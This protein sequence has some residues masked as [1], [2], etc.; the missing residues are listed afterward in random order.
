MIVTAS[1]PGKLLLLGDHAVVYDHPCIVTAVD[2]RYMVTLETVT[3]MNITISTPLLEKKKISRIVSLED[4]G[5]SSIQETSFVEAA[6]SNVFRKFN[7]KSG[8]LMH[9]NGPIESYGLGSSSAVV[10]ATISALSLA[11]NLNLSP[12]QI[13]NLAYQAVLDVQGKGSGFDVA[14]AIWGGTL[15]YVT[16]GKTIEPLNIDEIPITI[17]YSGKKVSTANLVEQVYKLRQK[18]PDIIDTI[19]ALS[20][21]LVDEA[22]AS[23][24]QSDWLILGELLN[25]NQG[26]LDALG[27]ST[28]KLANLIFSSRDA[29]A[30]GAKLSGAGRGD[31]MFALQLS[32]K[33]G[34]VQT[35]IKQA[36][37]EVVNIPINAKGAYA[38]ILS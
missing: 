1:A 6:I 3:D 35:A 15:Y 8:L 36:G 11:F 9:T 38:T 22:K 20:H 12:L 28:S 7:I 30:L 5:I 18:Q 23:L 33:K 19:F 16:G 27:V 37:G 17:G 10:V 26:L 25:I 24:L 32:D 4:V 2:I 34:N 31:C 13:F 21:K 14:S 29:G